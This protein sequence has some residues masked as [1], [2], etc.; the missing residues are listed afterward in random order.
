MRAGRSPNLRLYPPPRARSF[1][2]LVS[3]LLWTSP[4][5]RRTEPSF[6]PDRSPFRRQDPPAGRSAGH[7]A[8]ILRS[9]AVVSF[10]AGQTAATSESKM[11]RK[12]RAAA[13]VPGPGIRKPRD[14]DA[15]AGL[16]RLA[17]PCVG[18]RSATG[19]P[20]PPACV[21]PRNR[22]DAGLRVIGLFE[23]RRQL[24][25]AA[26][27]QRRS[28]QPARQDNARPPGPGRHGA[29]RVRCDW[30]RR[31]RG[32][33]GCGTR[34]R[35]RQRGQR[36]SHGDSVEPPCHRTPSQAPSQPGPGGVGLCVSLEKS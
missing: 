20:A 32:R 13:A 33:L 30:R 23:S 25:A 4:A 10:P 34:Q 9:G 15:R 36:E 24:P 19:R 29:I 8:G 2:S 22:I 31:G 1:E 6:T 18:R 3:T 16:I 26:V 28:W 17:S 12:L 35:G 7:S 11:W 14:S 21:D 5:L 27:R